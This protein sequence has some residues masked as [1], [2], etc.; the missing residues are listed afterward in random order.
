M[1]KL[2]DRRHD[3]IGKDG[4]DKDGEDLASR[5]AIVVTHRIGLPPAPVLPVVPICRS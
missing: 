2:Q 1:R 5:W 3:A 4:E